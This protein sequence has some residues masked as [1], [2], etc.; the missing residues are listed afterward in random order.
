L[1]TARNVA[2]NSK[3]FES[4]KLGE[5]SENGGIGLDSMQQRVNSPG[6][7]FSI[8]SNPGEGTIVKAEWGID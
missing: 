2:N 6:G 3:W 4:V 1:V 7:I 5:K 8:S